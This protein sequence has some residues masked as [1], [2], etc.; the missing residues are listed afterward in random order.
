MD[1]FNSLMAAISALLAVGGGLCAIGLPLLILG[2]LGV[3]LYRQRQKGSA[4]E[5]AAQEW[6]S[7]TGT[8]LA[9]KIQVRRTGRSRSEIPVV[10][11]QYEVKGKM[12]QGNTIRAGKQYFNVRMAGQ[13]QQT[14]ARYAAGK[15]VTVYYDRNNPAQS[16]LER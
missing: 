5:L 2:G 13:A 1:A 9:S 8:V 16:A 15:K 12:F 10:L 3:F 7:T 4:A 14:V 11:Y 6:L